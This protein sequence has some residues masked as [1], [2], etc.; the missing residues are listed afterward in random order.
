[1]N[2]DQAITLLTY[3]IKDIAQAKMI[4]S[5]FLGVEPYVDEPH[6]VGYKVG[7]NGRKFS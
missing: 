1:V 4:Y 3:P 2:K 6:Y 7:D 5:K